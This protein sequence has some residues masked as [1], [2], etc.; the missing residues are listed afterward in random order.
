MRADNVNRFTRGTSV[1]Y[2]G[3]FQIASYS[4]VETE[5]ERR[6]HDDLV[7]AGFDVWW[8]A[9]ILPGHEWKAEIQRARE[10]SK[11]GFLPGS[12]GVPG[13]WC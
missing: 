9:D 6:L 8:D 10:R 1:R 4:N 5:N 7:A 12:S 3:A 11:V 2:P 13:G